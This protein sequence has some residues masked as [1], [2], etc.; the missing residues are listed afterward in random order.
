MRYASKEGQAASLALGTCVTVA[1]ALLSA[2]ALISLFRPDLL[3]ND[4]P[5]HYLLTLRTLLQYCWLLF[6]LA[7]ALVSF[8]LTFAW[9]SSSDSE[10]RLQSRCALSIDVVWASPG[11]SCPPSKIPW[12]VWLTLSIVRL[13]LTLIIIVCNSS[14]FSILYILIKALDLLPRCI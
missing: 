14:R 8:A 12:G 2:S 9:R 5:I 11:S 6:L 4:I 7:P 13:L 10:V 3:L 1:L